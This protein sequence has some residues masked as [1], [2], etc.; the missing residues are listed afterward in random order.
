MFGMRLRS[1][2]VSYAA[3]CLPIHAFF[4]SKWCACMVTQKGCILTQGGVQ[5]CTISILSENRLY[6]FNTKL[7]NFDLMILIPQ[8]DTIVQ[9]LASSCVNLGTQI[10]WTKDSLTV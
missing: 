4:L 2:T 9:C 1:Y 8:E 5:H 10:L 6:D 7:R 3:N